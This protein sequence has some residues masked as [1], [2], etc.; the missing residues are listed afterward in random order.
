MKGGYPFEL[1]IFSKQREPIALNKRFTVD[2]DSEDALFL[3]GDPLL[4]ERLMI[5]LISQALLHTP[6]EETVLLKARR[7]KWGIFLEVHG[8]ESGDQLFETH[9]LVEAVGGH[10]RVESNTAW[11]GLPLD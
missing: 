2:R 5:H 11:I 3:Q 7:E 10:L 1:Y 9:R 6:A 4:L 8:Y